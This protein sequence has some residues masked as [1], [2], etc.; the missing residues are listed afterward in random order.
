MSRSHGS[1]ESKVATAVG[2]GLATVALGGVGALAA[3]AIILSAETR[4]ISAMFLASYSLLRLPAETQPRARTTKSCSNAGT[5]VSR[6]NIDFSFDAEQVVCEIRKADVLSSNCQ[7]SKISSW[8]GRGRRTLNPWRRSSGRPSLTRQTGEQTP[9]FVCATA[10]LLP[11]I[12]D[13]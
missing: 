2:L 4:V 12:I 3:A 7:R 13:A 9:R 8:S 10:T 11:Y 1:S 5:E 6:Q